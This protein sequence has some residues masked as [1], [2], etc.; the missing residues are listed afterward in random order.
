[1]LSSDSDGLELQ[2]TSQ[3]QDADPEE[4]L[5]GDLMAGHTS[6]VAALDSRLTSLQA[7]WHE[8]SPVLLRI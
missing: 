4:A 8:T 6:I 1:M 2:A 3:S 5:I 7:C